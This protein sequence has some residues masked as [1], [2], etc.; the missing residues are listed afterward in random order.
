MLTTFSIALAVS[1]GLLAFIYYSL[2]VDD[3]DDINYIKNS[4]SN[5]YRSD[6]FRLFKID[7]DGNDIEE[8]IR[9][10]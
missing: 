10:E 2:F 5:M 3:G 1:I 7:N 6:G 8:V 4:E 9:H